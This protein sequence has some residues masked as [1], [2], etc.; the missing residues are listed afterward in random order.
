MTQSQD[1]FDD[2][3]LEVLQDFTNNDVFKKGGT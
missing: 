3:L 2:D 1:V